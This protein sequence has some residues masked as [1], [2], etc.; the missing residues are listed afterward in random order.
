MIE[1]KAINAFTH[2]Q[3]GALRAVVCDAVWS[4]DRL[5]KEGYSVDPVCELCKKQP[6]SIFH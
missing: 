1:S 6:D 4:K 5:I 3:K 2:L